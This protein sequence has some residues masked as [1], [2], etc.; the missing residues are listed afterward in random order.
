M[1]TTEGTMLIA[2]LILAASVLAGMVDKLP[3][4]MRFSRGR[5]HHHG[6]IGGGGSSG[7]GGSCGGDGGGG[8]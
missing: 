8:D 6:G 4:W 7:D 2:A 3:E 1:T 5:D